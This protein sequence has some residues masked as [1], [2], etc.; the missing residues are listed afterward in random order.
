[1]TLD[2]DLNLAV[3]WPT[4]DELQLPRYYCVVCGWKLLVDL[5]DLDFDVNEQSLNKFLVE[6][7]AQTFA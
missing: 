5:N 2:H 6:Q 3:K 4:P 7:H 1:M